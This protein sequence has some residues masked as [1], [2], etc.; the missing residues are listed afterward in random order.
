[1]VLLTRFRFELGLKF[2]YM[3]AAFPEILEV[4]SSLRKVRL[5]ATGD[6]IKVN[7]HPSL[8]KLGRKQ[9]HQLM[10]AFDAIAQYPGY[11]CISW[12]LASTR[13]LF[14]AKMHTLQCI[15]SGFDVVN[16]WKI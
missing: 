5:L 16:K 13:S 15:Q 4:P 3:T 10:D 11:V 6:T 14:I 9:V 7:R 8:G 1:M 2:R 12:R